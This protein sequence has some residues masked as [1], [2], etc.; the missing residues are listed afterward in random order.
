MSQR[1]LR[2]R[3]QTSQVSFPLGLARHLET[4]PQTTQSMNKE[5]ERTSPPS[6]ANLPVT[7]SENNT[8]HS[9]SGI[10][11]A[12]RFPWLGGMR[13]KPAWGWLYSTL[14]S[15]HL[16]FY[17]SGDFDKRPTRVDDQNEEGTWQYYHEMNS[18][19]KKGINQGTHTKAGKG[20]MSHLKGFSH[21][22][23]ESLKLLWKICAP[24][25]TLASWWL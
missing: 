7:V 3:L 2:A 21:K 11:E 15:G 8:N 17:T 24:T 19:R 9:G 18:W 13:E 23:L 20:T 10:V 22:H 12:T 4:N 5:P 1:L 25:P 16:F 6:W 14:N